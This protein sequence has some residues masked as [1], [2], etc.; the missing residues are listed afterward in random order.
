MTLNPKTLEL[1]IMIPCHNEAENLP[2]LIKEIVELNLTSCEVLIIDDNSIDKTGEVAD[3]LSQIYPAVSVIH[4][5]PPK[6]RGLAGKDG[7]QWCLAH[8]PKYML[9]MD[10]DHSH[11]PKHIPEMLKAIK[12]GQVDVVI[13]SRYAL[14]GREVR[15]WGRK[16]LSYVAEKYLKQL[17][18]LPQLNDPSSGFRL[19][20]YD[21]VKHFQPETLTSPDH[22][23]TT[24]I[25]WRI[26]D[27]KIKEVP[28]VF[29][30]R[31]FG[32]TKLTWPVIVKSCYSPLMWRLKG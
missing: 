12:T 6:G 22:R 5:H 10:A 25:L 7:W 32:Q 17:F 26:R 13:G 20:T 28:I 14:G 24:E 16:L 19:F 11:D 15:G 18:H 9:E 30:D 31:K 3:K 4:R 23:I 29:H 21:A 8:K 27:L 2:L 1:G